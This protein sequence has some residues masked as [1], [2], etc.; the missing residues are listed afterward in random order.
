MKGA[1]AAE[2]CVGEKSGGGWDEAAVK[3]QDRNERSSE[4]CV[5]QGHSLSQ[6]ALAA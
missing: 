3:P 5:L 1:D 4:V 6:S 2:L